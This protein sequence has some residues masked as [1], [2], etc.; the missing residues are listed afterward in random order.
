MFGFSKI[1]K[2][3]VKFRNLM[4]KMKLDGFELVEHTR[5]NNGHILKVSIPPTSNFAEF[6]KRK[7]NFEKWFKGIVEIENV[8]FSRLLE[9]KVITKDIGKYEFAPVKTYP[10]KLYIAREFDEEPFFI[11][12]DKEGHLLI[13]GQTGTGK[14]FVLA[15]ILT[16][17]I[18]NCSDYVEIYLS[19][20]MKGEVGLFSNCK[21]VKGTQYTLEEVSATLKKVARE[22]DN[23]S[24]LFTS[25]GC[26]NLTHYNIN[27]NSKKLKRIFYVIE[28]VSFFIPNKEVDDSNTFR[29]KQE[30]W[31]SILII[32]K[33]GRSAGV[34]FM[35]VTQRSTIANVPSEVKAQMCC[36]T[37]QQRSGRDSENI[38]DVPDAKDLGDRECYVWGR[39]GLKL[40]KVPFVDEDFKDL[41]KY[42]PQIKLPN[43]E[44]APVL[45]VIPKK[46]SGL[47]RE[48][49]IDMRVEEY[50]KLQ[51]KQNNIINLEEVATEVEKPKKPKGR[52]SK[53]GVSLK[54]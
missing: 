32:A 1:E 38:I 48:S 42:V 46:E 10:N 51:E 37:M 11:D 34:H 19:Q 7:P 4:T 50:N 16:N 49:Y 24:K 8:K 43:F 44:E 9:L 5:I 2:E 23:R 41:N 39:K 26:K 47:I 21:S 40:L 27:T 13:A 3:R 15:T 52:P 53:K 12:L 6:E 35:S 33:A 25:K 22:V 28:E 30:C 29:L 36:M 14:S 18:Y 45:N 20:I 31:E 54:C 17:L